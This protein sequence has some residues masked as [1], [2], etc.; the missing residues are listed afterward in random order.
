MKKET[1]NPHKSITSKSTPVKA[2]AIRDFERFGMPEDIP[3]LLSHAKED[4]SIA[5]RLMAA[6]AV[7]DILSIPKRSAKS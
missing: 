4:S 1:E 3:L 7:S 5:I 2:A 6:D